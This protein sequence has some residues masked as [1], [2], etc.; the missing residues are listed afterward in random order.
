[1]FNEIDDADRSSSFSIGI[2]EVETSVS[3]GSVAFLGNMSF[4]G[5]DL[6]YD[7]TNDE[8]DVAFSWTDPFG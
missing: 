2:T 1:M 5:Y 8:A 4:G 6:T 3:S 7:Q